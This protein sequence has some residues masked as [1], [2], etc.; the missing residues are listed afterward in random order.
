[1]KI[2]V[3][4]QATGNS[5]KTQAFVLTLCALLFALCVSAQ[6][7]QPTKVPRIGFLI[8]SNPSPVS[9]RLEAF[10]QGL[11]EL[12]Y[13]EGKS[14]VIDYRWAEGKVDRMPDLAAQLI[15]LK[16]DIILSTVRNQPVPPKKQLLRFPLLWGLIMTL[17]AMGL[18]PALRAR[19][20]TSLDCQP[21]PRR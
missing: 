12:G 13:V 9:A 19:A 18:S 11:R 16:V 17:W 1:M 14:I 4:H 3:R 7:Q 20:E 6:A 5:P 10:R 8:A 15:G 21:L 2:G